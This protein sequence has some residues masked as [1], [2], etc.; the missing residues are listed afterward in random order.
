MKKPA[1]NVVVEYKNKRARKKSVSLWGNLDLKTIAREVEADTVQ[2]PV[3]APAD[4]GLPETAENKA[5][6][7]DT[8]MGLRVVAETQVPEARD[9]LAA[10]EIAVPQPAAIRID[11]AKSKTAEKLAVRQKKRSGQ[12]RPSNSMLRETEMVT[13]PVTIPDIRVE[14]SM[15]EQENADLKRELIAKLSEENGKLSG[16][17]ERAQHRSVT[18]RK[19]SPV[20]PERRLP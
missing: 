16:M 1:R 3:T 4:P 10:A 19:M 18:Y 13:R 8:N 14:L 20:Q 15:L 9:E 2:S 7:K 17:L 11:P 12:H 6:V 5:E